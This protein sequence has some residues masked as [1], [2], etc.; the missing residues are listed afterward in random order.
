MAQTA[1]RAADGVLALALSSASRCASCLALSLGCLPR[2]RPFALA[3][4]MPSRVR[5]RSSQLEF[6]DHRRDVE[7][8]PADAVG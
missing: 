8:Q 1:P 4:F 7:Q 5:I 6:G 3:T 2:D